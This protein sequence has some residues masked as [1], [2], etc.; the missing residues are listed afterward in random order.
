MTA[1]TA[2]HMVGKL[3]T[4]FAAFGLPEVVVTDNGPPFQSDE[5]GQFLSANGVKHVRTPHYHTQSNGA[6]ELQVQTVKIALRRQLQEGRSKAHTRTLQHMVNVF[7]FAYRNTPHSLTKKTP[8]ELFLQRQP[9]TRLSL[10]KPSFSHDMSARQEQVKRGLDHKRGPPRV[11]SQG[12]L[13]WIK[14]VRGEFNW[15][16]R[17]VKEVVSAVTYRVQEGSH[18]RY[19]HADHLKLRETRTN[20]TLRPGK[21]LVG[22]YAGGQLGEEG[23]VTEPEAETVTSAPE[24]S[25]VG[26]ASGQTPEGRHPSRVASG[27]DGSLED[28]GLRG[29]PPSTP[30]AAPYPR[31]SGRCVKVPRRLDL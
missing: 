24:E 3:R 12:D 5:F 26:K 30:V 2:F 29:F 1:T 21:H 8:E 10:L 31:R 22:K 9:R 13:V 17:S 11:F 7:L 20:G 23:R 14:T 18:V 15:V 4:L 16:P 28:E 6:V 19:V 25:H 27:G